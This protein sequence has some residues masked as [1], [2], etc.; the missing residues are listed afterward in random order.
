M[1]AQRIC[2]LLPSTTEILCALG[3][4]D[5]LVAVTHEC[6]YPREVRS[7]PRVT[8][9]AIEHEGQ[10]GR[11]IHN[12]IR[13]AL[14][15]GSSIYHLDQEL[16]QRLE[17]DLILTQELCAVCA[18]SYAQVDQAARL[19]PRGPA[20]LSLEPNTLGEILESIGRVGEATGRQ[21][22]AAQVVMGLR[23]RIAEVAS[24]VGDP[25]ERSR[26]LCLEWLDP[27]MVAGHWVPEMVWLAGGVDVLGR[28]GEPSFQVSWKEIAASAPSL[29]VLM[30]CGF[31]LQETLREVERT[32]FPPQ[33]ER[34]PAIRHDGVFAVDGS[35]YFNR[36]GPRIV[37]GL[38]L[39]A[40]ILQPQRF[41]PR[42]GA[43]AFCRVEPGLWPA[44][45]ARAAL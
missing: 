15:Q 7:K 21:R 26:L 10:S 4:G 44:G 33:W 23:R 6:D 41:P 18:V 38:E 11:Q 14:H 45:S 31:H 13:E 32:H 17:P 40:G 5:V 35:S 30:P 36:P 34:L 16:L 20:V 28:A 12:H 27:P 43:D 37:D 24:A 39:L 3:L 42:H 2:S 29:V 8:R 1:A 19:L 25:P 9:S 22:Q